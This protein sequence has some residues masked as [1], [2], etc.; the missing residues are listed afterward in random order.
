MSLLSVLCIILLIIMCLGH[1]FPLVIGQ[2]DFCSRFNSSRLNLPHHAPIFNSTRLIG[3]HNKRHVIYRQ[4]GATS[5]FLKDLEAGL[6]CANL[7]F[8]KPPHHDVHKVRVAHLEG[9]QLVNTSYTSDKALMEAIWTI[10]NSSIS[11]CSDLAHLCHTES[12]MAEAEAILTRVASDLRS[13][14][15]SAAMASLALTLST[16]V[17]RVNGIANV[18][19]TLSSVAGTLESHLYQEDLTNV[20]THFLAPFRDAGNL[21]LREVADLTNATTRAFTAV[22]IAVSEQASRVND[23]NT[24]SAINVAASKIKV[25]MQRALDRVSIHSLTLISHFT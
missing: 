16:L 9:L 19:H 12:R 24:R 22:M 21:G 25:E 2:G 17:Q 20:S 15:L 13:Q 23:S 6:T 8:P 1:L 11:M 14:E 4:V 10:V 18:I 5:T 3:P 7:Q